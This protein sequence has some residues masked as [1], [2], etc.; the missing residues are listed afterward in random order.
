M[1]TIE[2]TSGCISVCGEDVGRDLSPL[3]AHLGVVFQNN[4][5]VA[6]VTVREH[7]TLFARLNGVHSDRV[8]EEVS[9]ISSQFELNSSL[10]NFASTLSGGQQRILCVAIAMIR[11]PSVI[12]MDEPTAGLDVQKRQIVWNAIRE[13]HGLTGL[14]TCHSVEE[15]ETVSTRI[16]VMI[17]GQSGFLGTASE[18]RKAYHCG[19]Y[20]TFIDDH[21]DMDT[22]LEFIQGMEPSAEIHFDRPKSIVVPDTLAMTDLLEGLDVNKTRLRFTNYT[23]HIESLEDTMWKLICDAEVAQHE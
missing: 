5:L 18:M 10:E 9:L 11:H 19:Y 15:G 7:L 8:Q 13:C 23:V 1:N 20:I 12:I 6:N 17:S 4:S 16:M 21:V 22:I 2:P 3:Y 14:V